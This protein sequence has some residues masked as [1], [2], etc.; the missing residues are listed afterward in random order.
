MKKTI[1]LLLVAAV[2]SAFAQ[3]LQ[4]RR[5]G[6]PLP[7]RSLGGQSARQPA[8]P[9]AAA[10]SDASVDE[11]ADGSS[12]NFNQTA[13]DLVFEA[14]G[15]M[16]GKTILK[17][18]Q[19]PAATITLKSEKGQKLT[20]EEQIEAIE[21]VLE[22]NGVHLE[23]Y[24]EKFM[25]ALPRK[26]A[27]KEGIP[28]IMD[29]DAQLRESGKVVSMMLP[30]KN[31]SMEDAQKI[32]DQFKSA[33]GILIAI[34]RTNSI[35]ITDTE[36]NINRMREVAKTIDVATPVLENVFVRQIKNA[37]ATEIKTA[38]EAIV[39][40]SQKELE[41]SKGANANVAQ[42]A[43]M[44]R[45]SLLGGLRRP[46]QNQPPA[47]ASNSSL[48][49]TVSDA[50]RGMIRGKVLILADERSTT[51]IIVTQKANLDF[52]DKVIEQLD[53]ETTPDTVVKVYRLKY[54]D[55][56][57]VSD[58]INDL[59]GNSTSSKN[60]SKNSQNANAKK[61]TGGNITRNNATQAKK[62]V[63]QR[64]GEAKA[65]ELSK[66]NTTVL[67]DKRING[68][69]V[70]TD[71][72][73]VPTLEQIIES[74]DIKLS[75]VLIETAIIE[76]S[77]GDDLSTG[78]NWSRMGDKV[79]NRVTTPNMGAHGLQ[80]YWY[81][82]SNGQWQ[83]H[84]NVGESFTTGDG[85]DEIT[86][87]R[88]G[89]GLVDT[90][91]TWT[92]KGFVS[93][94]GDLTELLGG[95]GSSGS[96]A[97]I[98]SALAG[99][100]VSNALSAVSPAGS[101]LNWFFKSDKLNI[102]AVI[103]AT[104][105]DSRTKYL[106][107][108]VIMTLDNKEAT[109]NATEMS[110][111][112]RGFQSSGNSYSTIAVPDYEQKELGIEIKVTPKI[113]PNGTVMLTV[114]TKYTQ[115]SGNQD[116]KYA[117]GGN[118]GD[119]RLET[120]NVPLTAT[121]EMSSDVLLENMQTV[122]F[123]GLVKNFKSESETGIPILKD[124]PIIGK[125]LFGSVTQNEKRNELLIFMTPYV[126]DDGEV[127]Q[128]EALRR[129]KTMS[130]PRPWEDN[131]WSLSNLADPVAKKEQMRRIKE[132][133]KK[134]D[135]ERQ[136][137]IAIE[138]MKVD[139]AKK[140]QSLTK[141]ERELWLKM[142]K[143]EL[144]DEKQEELEEK[145]LDEKSQDELKKLAEQVRAKKLKAAE[146]ELK[147]A[148]EETAADNERAKLDAAKKAKAETA[149]PAV[150]PAEAPKPV[151]KPAEAPKAAAPGNQTLLEALATEAKEAK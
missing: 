139:R 146:A 82:G 92:R 22:M 30:F 63:N 61:G 4:P 68:L 115:Q 117:S 20:K 130:D 103:Q 148:E 64:S 12:L 44:P 137:K 48:V 119:S 142:H 32:L 140:L 87:N 5:V 125:W 112:L 27:R 90:A 113:N 36:V 55:A 94:D 144:D 33:T 122:V 72:E 134:Q 65:G 100:S 66:D 127:A 145:M 111:L 70:M 143:D 53:V 129:K 38:L 121:R 126:L 123:G 114:E 101:G 97:G 31:I 71:K 43:N 81:Q 29:P 80:N 76:V 150:K 21:V 116:I 54:A 3:G 128:S 107:S 51:L 28:L 11:L 109:I 79:E 23:P 124:I 15:R 96:A 10:V 99:A 47:P 45:P 73:L 7:R 35:L 120:V 102:A 13:I 16:V 83:K 78:V 26:D 135:E 149:K 85:S 60:S 14:Y 62:S 89:E 104:Q 69:V 1:A 74:M 39:Q 75:Q 88:M 91:S 56:E 34:E 132:E 106:A 98:I 131:G 67:A 9:A 105:S 6:M 18:P 77:L 42:P 37:N 8:Q 19:C 133:W 46:G 49:M 84:E 40:E 95:G 59:I 147:K 41:K 108:P 141:E 110:Y 17:D 136:T 58:M 50:D 86:W 93:N 25:R 2:G 52:F 151:V 24:G 118:Q 138:K 57:D